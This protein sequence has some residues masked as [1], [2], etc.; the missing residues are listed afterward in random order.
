MGIT[1]L[2]ATSDGL[3]LVSASIDGS[4]RVWDIAKFEEIRKLEGHDKQVFGL[5]MLKNNRHVVSVGRDGFA[6]QW[7]LNTGSILSKIRAHSGLS[8]AVA[9]SPDGRF[10]ISSGSDERARVWHLPSGDR[11]GAEIKDNDEPKP[12]LISSHPGAKLFPK[13]AKCH[14]LTKEGI[15]RSGPHFSNLFG[16]KAGSVEDYKYSKALVD[17]DF[18]W[19]EQSLFDL[20][21]KGPDKY[22]PGTK[23]PVQR[24][25]DKAQLR[26]LIAYLKELTAQPK[27]AN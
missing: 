17:V 22:L 27:A 20:F 1:Q 14:A 5:Q 16:R 11:I 6:I 26:E 8:W 13:C 4:L 9:A 7:D 19:D 18:A 3:F 24:V 12:W 25:T 10:I 21:D 23:M 15:R 2:A